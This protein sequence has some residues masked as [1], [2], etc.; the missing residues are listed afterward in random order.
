ME[1]ETGPPSIAVPER[2][3]PIRDAWSASPFHLESQLSRQQRRAEA[4][5][6]RASLGN[7]SIAR[8]ETTTEGWCM[9]VL[10][11][12]ILL[13]IVVNVII[14]SVIASQGDMM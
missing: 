1:F 12:M 14:G 9:T 2:A 6:S 4:R 10:A 3:Y 13:P 7:S 11:M 5:R 8:T